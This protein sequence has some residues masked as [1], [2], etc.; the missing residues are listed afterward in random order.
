MMILISYVPASFGQ[1]YTVP[2]LKNSNSAYSKSITVNLLV[3]SSL[4]F[5]TTE[6]LTVMLDTFGPATINLALK[7]NTGAVMGSIH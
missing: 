3:Q 1:S 2:L 4:K 7:R 6:F 5:L